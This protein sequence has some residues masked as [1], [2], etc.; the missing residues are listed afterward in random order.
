MSGRAIRAELVFR[1]VPIPSHAHAACGS[2][3]R[4][5]PIGGT[6]GL[7]ASDLTINLRRVGERRTWPLL[8]PRAEYEIV[9]RHTEAEIYRARTIAPSGPL[10]TR[11]GVHT[12]DSYDWV[13]AA[14]EAYARHDPGWISDPFATF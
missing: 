10:V 3:T 1:R 9:I 7:M 14:D 8:R 5:D 2:P 6:L 4:R 12:T 13:R 11:G